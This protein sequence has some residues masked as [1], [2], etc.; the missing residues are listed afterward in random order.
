MDSYDIASP[1]AMLLVCVKIGY[2]TPKCILWSHSVWLKC[3]FFGIP[4]VHTE[5]NVVSLDMICHVQLSSHCIR[6][7]SPLH[8]NVFPYIIYRI[9]IIPEFFMKG[10]SGNP[11]KSHEINGKTRVP[12]RFSDSDRRTATPEAATLVPGGTHAWQV[13]NVWANH[14]CKT[15]VKSG[16]INTPLF[17]TPLLINLLLPKKMQFKNRWPPR[18]NKPFG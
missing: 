12:C 14:T 8:T 11:G 4:H 5:P 3:I 6:M 15:N 10:K 16:L 1:A 18:I 7:I 9:L 2:C 13:A 17:N